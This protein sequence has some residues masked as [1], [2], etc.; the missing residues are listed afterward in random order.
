MIVP[1]ESHAVAV[2]IENGVA[3]NLTGW[4]M[5]D[6]SIHADDPVHKVQDKS[7]VVGDHEDGETLV[8][9]TEQFLEFDLP[10]GVDVGHRLVEY[11]QPRR[12]RKCPGEQHALALT[13]A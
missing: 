10:A 6:R 12:R 11:E 8:K 4:V 5:P 3:G 2:Q 9:L 7:H 13:A 1:D